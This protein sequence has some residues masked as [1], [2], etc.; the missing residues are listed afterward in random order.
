MHKN[1][2]I[3]EQI[4]DSLARG[5]GRYA[6]GMTEDEIRRDIRSTTGQE[7]PMS[8]I[9]VELVRLTV[10]GTVTTSIFGPSVF[11]RPNPGKIP[12]SLL[13]SDQRRFSVAC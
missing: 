4:I 11:Y 10:E 2:L 13:D 3:R 7:Y 6:H 5:E 8:D 9:R 1:T 12:G